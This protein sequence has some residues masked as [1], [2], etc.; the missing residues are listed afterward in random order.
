MAGLA[1][2]FG[3][4]HHAGALGLG[5][6]NDLGSTMGMIGMPGMG[7]HASQNAARLVQGRSQRQQAIRI[8]SNAGAAQAGIDLDQHTESNAEFLAFGG[9]GL[10]RGHIIGDQLEINTTSRAITTLAHDRGNLL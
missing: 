3:G 7:Q 2:P 9:D 1:Q 8:R 4:T 5:N 6:G 10:R